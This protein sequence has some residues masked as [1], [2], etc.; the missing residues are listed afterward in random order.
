YASNGTDTIHMAFTEGHPRNLQTSIYYARYRAGTIYRANGTVV[1]SAAAL[2]FTPAQADKVY[3]AAAH[4]G[5]KAWIH[6]VG[7]DVFG[8]PVV[9]FATFPTDTDHRYHY[10]RWDGTRWVDHEIARAGGTMS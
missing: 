1:K 3:D 4:G 5:V 10:A 2:P 6:D 8:R 9:T 7:V